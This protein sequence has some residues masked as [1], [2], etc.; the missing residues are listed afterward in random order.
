[1]IIR[2][3]I[4]FFLAF[5]LFIACGDTSKTSLN[6]QLGNENSNAIPTKEFID[7]DFNLFIDKFSND[8]TFQLS[9]TKFPLKIRWYDIDNDNDYIF[10]ENKSNFEIIDFRKKKS[11]GVDNQWEQKINLDTNNTSAIIEIK[12]I[13][14]GI[15]VNYFFEKINGAWILTAI[16]DIST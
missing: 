11:T 8:S 14:N 2:S 3:Y 1:M 7:S 9:R 15:L 13:E 16:E 6:K 4:I 10:Y 5:I 12:G